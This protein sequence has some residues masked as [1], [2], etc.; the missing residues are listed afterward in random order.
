MS[1]FTCDKYQTHWA[2]KRQSNQIFKLFD[3]VM[4]YP[5][6]RTRFEEMTRRYQAGSKSGKYKEDEKEKQDDNSNE[7]EKGKNNKILN[8][9]Y[10]VKGFS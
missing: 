1:L 3:K 4:G 2:S 10:Q 9:M 5:K 8:E 6:Q 7:K